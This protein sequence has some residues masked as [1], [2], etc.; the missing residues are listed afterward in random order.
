MSELKPLGLLDHQ[1]Q[2]YAARHRSHVNLWVHA[3]AVPA[4]LLGNVALV[5][6]LAALHWTIAGCALFV[7]LVALGVQGRGHRREPVAPEPFTGR[8]N[9]VARLL[10][11][12]WITF[13]RFVLS[14]GW[15]AAVKAPGA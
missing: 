1:W 4:F 3:G 9:A 12:Q 15:W 13:P 14:G 5:L 8:R 11:E 7:C 6:A 10:A 2:G